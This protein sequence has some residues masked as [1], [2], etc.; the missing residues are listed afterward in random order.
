MPRS[1]RK[2]N[3]RAVSGGNVSRFPIVGV[4]ASAGGLEALTALL[5]ELPTNTGMTFLLVQHLD[6]KHE[7]K[8]TDL[9][10]KATGMKV[11]EAREGMTMC[12]NCVFVIPPNK[13]MALVQGVLKL[14]PRG[15]ARLPHLAVDILFKSLAG[16]LK[17]R[18]IGVVLSGTGSDGSQGLAEI[19]AAGGI[20]FAQD[21]AS[22]KYSG[23][24]VSAVQSG[25]VDFVLPP[26][27]IAR[28]LVRIGRHPYVAHAEESPPPLAA[29]ESD[30]YRKILALVRTASGVNFDHYRETT[31]RRRILR[32]MAVHSHTDLAEYSS[33]LEKNRPESHVLYEN[34]LIT[35]T[36]FFRDLAVFAAL[37]REVFP[38]LM[39]RNPDTI[40]IWSAGCSTGQETYSLAIAL[41]E[42]LENKP[43][44]PTVQ[45][46]GTDIA[47]GRSI[48]KAREGLYLEG[49]ER[50]VSP[51]R[52]QR[53]FTKETAGYRVRKSVR[54]L[55]VFA[56]QN[57]MAD[58][59]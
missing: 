58:P 52:L 8:L 12:A 59:P 37:Q 47:D 41:L 2:A 16:D 34:L 18:A 15:E 9:L 44:R 32:R 20:T 4:G 25:C 51:E 43:Q 27:G 1:S 39:R 6:P 31:I 55:C 48:E 19:K 29:P 49:I 54:E 11:T 42:F 35:V 3:S 57:V 14:T 33:Y 23:M 13:S 40:R 38:A 17:S 30:H 28:E 46:F 56:K 22:A 7:S 50:E 21:E 10:A 36:S 45:I 5:K 24:P 26:D 53:F